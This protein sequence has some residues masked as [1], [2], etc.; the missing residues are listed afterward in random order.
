[1]ISLIEFCIR[2]ILILKRGGIII[3]IVLVFVI[4]AKAEC[5]KT[6]LIKEKPSEGFEPSEGFFI[7]SPA[8]PLKWEEY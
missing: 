4:H 3:I 8:N 6:I 7:K 2:Y 5:V 1:M